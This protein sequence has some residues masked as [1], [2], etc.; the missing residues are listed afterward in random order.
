[1]TAALD[2]VPYKT[3][4]TGT[5]Q[6]AL[7]GTGTVGSALLQRLQRLEAIGP[8]IRLRLV[9]VANS[10]QAVSSMAGIDAGRTAGLLATSRRSPDMSDLETVFGPA[11]TRIVIDAT[12]CAQTA[13]R[14]ARWLQDGIHVVT[15]NKLALGGSQ[16]QWTQLRHAQAIGGTRY[17]DSATVGA[18]LP[19][20]RTIRALREGGDR[21]HALAGILSGSLAWLFDRFD[22]AQP[23]SRCVREAWK[24][25]YTEPDPREDL[26]GQ[27]VRRKLLILVRAAGWA[28][29]PEHIDVESL[30]TGAL[31]KGRPED[32]A[33]LL[34]GLDDALGARLDR[35]RAAGT[36][37]RHVARLEADGRASVGL[38]ALAPD[39][40][41]TSGRGTDNRVAIW[42][43]RYSER[44]LVIQGPG[45]GAGV[46]AA[47]LLDDV[48]AIARVAEPV[49][50]AGW[51][52]T[53]GSHA[54]GR[55]LSTR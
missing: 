23:F 27:D 29:E 48:L 44:P 2:P 26:S 21:I 24:A 33:G 41:L 32:V 9:H 37:L 20:L 46:T 4:P 47:A 12:A 30:S 14:H 17:G 55:H 43:E 38:V 39:D 50:R 8:D 3:G 18:G 54:A 10:R 35:A 13:A 1:M 45:A 31:S 16:A 22:G 28:L 6:L 36:V 52:R 51:K 15:A 5:V 40:P 34:D 11:V 25:G 42:S 53:R 49:S 7:L 19:L